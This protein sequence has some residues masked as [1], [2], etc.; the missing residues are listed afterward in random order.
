[1]IDR[2]SAVPLYYQIA[3]YLRAQISGG[4]LKPGQALPTEETLQATFHVSRATIR[5]AIRSLATSGLVRMDR[6]RGTFVNDLRLVEQLPTL[7]SFSDEVRRAGMR[8][9]A[10]VLVA[11]FELPPDPIRA[12]LRLEPNVEALL[13]SRLRLADGEPIAV[14]TSWIPSALG[15]RPDDDF[16]G[17][18]YDLFT[19]YGVSPL[20]AD[21]VLDAVNADRETAE[22]L[23]VPR[24]TALLCVTRT[25]FGARDTPIEYVV[26]RYRADRYRYSV[27][28][29]RDKSP[30]GIL[31]GVIKSPASPSAALHD[32]TRI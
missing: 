16:S 2:E 5:Q 22:L 12:Q 19:R 24:R 25:T 17:S 14:L 15:I 9:A 10:R 18:L 4:T 7:I 6:P 13:I 32:P 1:M 20:H 27:R 11:R 29:S 3:Q 21:Q 26:G 31:G 23:G 30:A 28:L 8:P